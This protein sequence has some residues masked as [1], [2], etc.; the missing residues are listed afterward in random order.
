[1][2][3]GHF[4]QV[5]W[6]ESKELGIGRAVGKKNGMTCTYIVGRYRPAGNFQ[7]K[8]QENVVRGSFSNSICG[9]LDDMIK[10]AVDA[11]AGRLLPPPGAFALEEKEDD[12]ESLF[13]D[14]NSRAAGYGGSFGGGNGESGQDGNNGQAPSGGSGMVLY[15]K[16]FSTKFQSCSGISLA[17]LYCVNFITFFSELTLLLVRDFRPRPSVYC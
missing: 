8:F 2:G 9:K 6:K 10:D 4:T 17:I 15:K 11:P 7:G 5:V 1:M 16:Y 12:I 3:T 13:G 14:G